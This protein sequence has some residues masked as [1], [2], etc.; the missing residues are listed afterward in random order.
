MGGYKLPA[1]LAHANLKISRKKN[2]LNKVRLFSVE[3]AKFGR[4]VY[5]VEY[6]FSWQENH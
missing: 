1:R 2:P 4:F 5:L 6:R 3:A